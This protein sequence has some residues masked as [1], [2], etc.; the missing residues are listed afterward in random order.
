M[1]SC[2]RPHSKLAGLLAAGVVFATAAAPAQTSAESE[3]I[4]LL[5]E[6]LRARQEGNLEQAREI[7]PS[8]DFEAEAEPEP[9]EPEEAEAQSFQQARVVFFDNVAEVRYDKPR[10]T[11][12]I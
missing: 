11:S 10:R 4:A 8:V 2:F 1:K 9:A 3:R 7:D 5:T 6:A 12:E